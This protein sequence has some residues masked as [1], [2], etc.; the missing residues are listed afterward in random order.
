[1]TVCA[2]GL[3]VGGTKIAGGIV[4]L[5]DGR[6]L[7]RQVVATGPERGGEAVLEDTLAL[8]EALAGQAQRLGVSI[9]G[10]GV[11][12]CELVDPQGNITSGHAVAW[13][14]LPVAKRL[15]RV[16]PAMVESDVRA[17]ALAEARYGA[18]RPYS[19]FAYV[20]VGTGISSCL[21][22]D[23]RPY[24]GARGNALILASSPWSTTCPACGTETGL[25]LEE[26]ASGP[27]LV[28]RYNGQSTQ[29]AARAEDI[30][31]RVESG[32]RIAAEVV[33][34]AGAAL[35]NSVGFLIN[36]LDPEAVVVGGGLGLAGGLY[37][38]SF[39]SSAREHIWAEATRGLPPRPRAGCRSCPRSSARMPA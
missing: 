11:G 12:V 1:M 36:I 15:A 37:W 3:D 4:D 9:Q 38:E 8:A 35:G 27:A 20:T 21:V 39:V 13:N 33:R 22:L 14:G 7:A 28:T 34:S 18:G 25:V 29:P 19:Q 31:A 16:A 5:D 10:I 6:V 24:A 32:D 23:G 17:A 30:L 26:F 2:I